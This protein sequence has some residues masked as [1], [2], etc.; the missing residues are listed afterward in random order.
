MSK[1]LYDRQVSD[2]AM[3]KQNK[4]QQQE[5]E[6]EVIPAELIQ[7]FDGDRELVQKFMDNGYTVE[8]LQ[9]STITHPTLTDP[10]VTL[11]NGKVAGF[12]L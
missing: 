10:V 3:N 6:Q 4:L 11:A 7:K 5:Q 1:Y 9:S 8:Q 2:F 12:W